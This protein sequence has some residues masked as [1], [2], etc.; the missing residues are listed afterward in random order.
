VALF[1]TGAIVYVVWVNRANKN[2]RS[3]GAQRMEFTPGWAVGWHFVPIAN[4]YRPYQVMKEIW[5]ASHPEY[6]DN[7]KTAP[8]SGLLG[9]WWAF[10]II[11]NIISNIG[12]RINMNAETVD[13]IL[14]GTWV[15]LASDI[16]DLPTI[17]LVL[18]V[19]RSV[20]GMQEE[21]HQ[22]VSMEQLREAPPTLKP[23][24]GY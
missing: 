12:F 17:A 19:V 10:W 2:A 23:W 6:R 3:L 22:Q 15:S 24:D 18:Y 7:W 4:L 1:I 14:L 21:K 16:I 13:A 8:T 9:L 5:K 20:H 11:G